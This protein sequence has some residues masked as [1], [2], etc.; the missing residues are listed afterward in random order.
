MTKSIGMGH[1]SRCLVLAKE[2][3][4]QK[5]YSVFC[6]R[7]FDNLPIPD[8]DND[9]IDINEDFYS[10]EYVDTDTDTNT[11]SIWSDN[12][13]AEDAGLLKNDII[14]SDFI[15]VDHYGLS[16]IFMGIVRA[17]KPSIKTFFITDFICSDMKLDFL[18]N[19]NGL[20]EK[21]RFEKKSNSVDKFLLGNDYAFVDSKFLK[22][23]SDSLNRHIIGSYQRNLLICFGGIDNQSLTPRFLVDGV[24]SEFNEI[25]ILVSSASKD[26]TLIRNLSSKFKNVTIVVDNFEMQI[27]MLWADLMLGSPGGMSWERA[28][29]SLPCVLV[30]IAKNQNEN[31]K[32]FF[33]KGA[34]YVL[35]NRGELVEEFLSVINDFSRCNYKKMVKSSYSICDG[36]G[37]R[38]V[39][40]QIL[41]SIYP[42][43]LSNVCINDCHQLWLWQN[44]PGARE[45]SYNSTPPNIKEHNLWFE[46]LTSFDIDNFFM[47]EVNQLKCGFIRLSDDGSG[48]FLVSILLSQFAQN[49]G[50]ATWGLKE[51]VNKYNGKLKAKIKVE[52]RSSIACFKKAGFVFEGGDEY[53][54]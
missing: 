10:S 39:L 14:N 5:C 51:I 52:N 8:I 24:V 19:S 21:R 23:R 15:I 16:S 35:E 34:C 11:E 44:E 31:A 18:L 17:I 38:R 46:R 13:Q 53:I 4:G 45:Y 42:K 37:S 40:L 22:L 49:V 2:L 30:V 26:I 43:K 48:R 27:H 3:A 25:R 28:V 47:I 12:L 33:E 20:C 9:Y 7:N 50:L 1:F 6:M 29:M 41:A 54:A 36:L 32:Y